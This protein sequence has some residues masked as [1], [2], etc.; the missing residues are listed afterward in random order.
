L[1]SKNLLISDLGS[2]AI[3]KFKSNGTVDSTFG[4]LGKSK[5]FDGYCNSRVLEFVG[6]NEIMY[7]GFK[8]GLDSLMHYHY[9][10]K[11]DTQL[12]FINNFNGVGYYQK[13]DGGLTDY[14]FHMIVNNNQEPI[15]TGFARS[16]QQSGFFGPDYYSYLL[17]A[18]N[19]GALKTNFGKGGVSVD[20]KSSFDAGKY[21]IQQSSGRYITCGFYNDTLPSV[22]NYPGL[23]AYDINGK[24]DSTFGKNGFTYF[25]FRDNHNYTNALAL[26][27]ADNIYCTVNPSSP[28]SELYRLHLIRFTKDGKID[29]TFGIYGKAKIRYYDT[30]KSKFNNIQSVI[31]DQNNK[32]VVC[33]IYDTIG[34]L[35][36]GIAYRRVMIARLTTNGLAD[37]T[38][39]YNG[40]FVPRLK[41]DSQICWRVEIDNKNRIVGCGYSQKLG[42]R[43]VLLFR[44]N[45]NGTYDSTFGTNGESLLNVSQKYIE[46]GVD[47][48]ILNDNKIVVAGYTADSLTPS[49][50]VINLNQFVY[51]VNEDGTPHTKF[52][53]NGFF[54]YSVIDTLGEL[55]TACDVLKDETAVYVSG[56]FTTK[57]N[58]VNIDVFL[59]KV[60]LGW[61]LGT[62]DMENNQQQLL[63]YP[64]PLQQQANFEFDLQKDNN[65]NVYIVD[66]SGK[67][68]QQVVE[69]KPFTQGHHLLQFNTSN[70][71]ANQIYHVVL[72][73]NGV[74]Q[75]VRVVKGE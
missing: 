37:S 61:P 24:R 21:L 33:G 22:N 27:N 56:Y 1:P 59:A 13:A 26:D 2:N 63:L 45:P 67:L 11:I 41:Q 62:I 69:N 58:S 46:E 17:Y 23:W 73:A 42:K 66:I 30:T 54:G 70:L 72:E 74:R 55:T 47:L 9:V 16:K 12:N 48:K 65:L 52:G 31:V 68:V 32:P 8:G 44:L 14:S 20:A 39:A 29:S 36:N 19:T 7:H 53:T 34:G 3:Y 64:N 75:F 18:N 51:L 43:K 4:V 5:V 6:N 57:F 35:A 49:S 25:K 15:V 10:A 60:L 28:S 40:I 71:I 38:F 50:N